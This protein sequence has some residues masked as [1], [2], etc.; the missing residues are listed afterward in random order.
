MPEAL[1]GATLLQGSMS[2]SLSAV[3]LLATAPLW[4][5]AAGIG[6]RRLAERKRYERAAAAEV[7]LALDEAVVALAW[8]YEVEIRRS[9]D[10]PEALAIVG[11]H[12]GQR[13]E[14][15]LGQTGW[16]IGV[17]VQPVLPAGLEVRAIDGG[18]LLCATSEAAGERV[19]V[20]DRSF[21]ARYFVVPPGAGDRI[22]PAVVELLRGR[23]ISGLRLRGDRLCVDALGR[24][25][26]GA[27][28]ELLSSLRE[29]LQLAR[30]LEAHAGRRPSSA[31]SDG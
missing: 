28:A 29:A 19:G 26:I 1:I 31:R 5:A 6:A 21:D 24:T 20:G 18:P 16:M 9:P 8:A 4:A 10:E 22:P 7:R 25:L 12:D 13:F 11:V 27:R 2:L 23:A 14:L 17:D 3:V 15:A 30:E